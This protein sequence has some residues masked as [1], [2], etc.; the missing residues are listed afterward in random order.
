MAYLGGGPNLGSFHLPA[1]WHLKPQN[2][3]LCRYHIQLK[4]GDRSWE[5]AKRFSE[6][7]SLLQSLATNRFGGLP[8]LPAKTL[9][10]SPM[11]QAAIDARK[12]QPGA[13]CHRIVLL[14]DMFLSA[15][16][17]FH[18]LNT[19][20]VADL[21]ARPASEASHVDFFSGAHHV[22][23]SHTGQIPAPARSLESFHHFKPHCEKLQTRA[24]GPAMRQ[25]LELPGHVEE[26]I[27]RCLD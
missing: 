10:G 15:S 1:P 20:E 6:F 2:A 4:Y 8:K 16:R 12:E 27:R 17:A 24:L 7:D 9:L 23:P 21:A 25:F 5:V 22:D 11:D 14:S 18:A 26:E 19:A 3:L 13:E